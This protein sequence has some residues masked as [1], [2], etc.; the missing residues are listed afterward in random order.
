[1]G[2]E[3]ARAIGQRNSRHAKPATEAGPRGE[4]TRRQR[5]AGE[6]ARPPPIDARPRAP[7]SARHPGDKRQS[8]NL[9]NWWVSAASHA[10]A[11]VRAP[12]VRGETRE[13]AEEREGGQAMLDAGPGP[14]HATRWLRP[15][16]PGFLARLPYLGTMFIQ[17]S[18]LLG[19]YRGFP[20]PSLI[21]PAHGAKARVF[22]EAGPPSQRRPGGEP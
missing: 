6:E 4:E 5:A 9:H 20:R 8:H 10:G 3:K 16:G 19:F 21:L 11:R 7:G 22:N 17:V 18:T 13:E 12:D 15:G 2:G 14:H 1:M